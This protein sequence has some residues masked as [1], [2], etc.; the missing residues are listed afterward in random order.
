ML[1]TVSSFAGDLKRLDDALQQKWIHLP[2]SQLCSGENGHLKDIF[3]NLPEDVQFQLG[4]MCLAFRSTIFCQMWKRQASRIEDIVIEDVIDCIFQPVQSNVCTN[5]QS[6]LDQTITL[7]RINKV[8]EEF[9][10]DDGPNNIEKEVNVLILIS[11]TGDNSIAQ[12]Q[13]KDVK[14]VVNKVFDFF[15]LQR[16]RKKASS[17]IKLGEHLKLRGDFK[18][19]E[20]VENEVYLKWLHFSFSLHVTQSTDVLCKMD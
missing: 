13:S 15:K 5:I 4:R 2:L 10:T 11:A 18:V 1:H 20:E 14:K 12:E 16:N 3:F 6:L 9:K 17:I 8:F 7:R 19:F